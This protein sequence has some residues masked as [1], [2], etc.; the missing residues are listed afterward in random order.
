MDVWR[1][2]PGGAPDVTRDVYSV[3]ELAE[4]LGMSREE[5]LHSIDAGELPAERA[6]G[7]VTRI[8]R[9]DALAWMQRRGPGI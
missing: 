1:D 2:R 9:E 3:D 7:S 5:V 4:L 8:K 6:A